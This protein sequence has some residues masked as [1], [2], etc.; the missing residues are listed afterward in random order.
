[1][2][3]VPVPGFGAGD[4]APGHTLSGFIDRNLLPGTL[5]RQVRDPEGLFG[6]I[7]AISTALLGALTGQWIR[8]GR[9]NEHLK[10]LGMLVCGLLFLAIGWIWDAAFPVNKNLWSSSFVMVAGGWSLILLSIFYWVID[11]LRWRAWAFPFVVIGMNAITIYMMRRFIDFQDVAAF[12]L[13][14]GESAMAAPVFG[15]MGF[16]VTWVV[17]YLMYRNKMF[18]RV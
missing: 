16:L 12:L 17:L 4:L 5:Y 18:L 15:C 1:M 11:V 10:S 6:L 14:K 13:G 2:T 9:A 8:H 7:P 3:W